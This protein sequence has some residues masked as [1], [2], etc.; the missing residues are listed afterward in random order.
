MGVPL[1]EVSTGL[2]PDERDMEH[3]GIRPQAL[4]SIGE[5]IAFQGPAVTRIRVGLERSLEFQLGV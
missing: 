4:E 1:G 5:A 2:G 3:R